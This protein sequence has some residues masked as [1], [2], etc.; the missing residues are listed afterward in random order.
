MRDVLQ[1][2]SGSNILGSKVKDFKIVLDSVKVKTPVLD[3]HP[4]RA[5]F[6]A[7]CK[8]SIK[9]MFRDHT[10]PRYLQG[11]TQNIKTVAPTYLPPIASVSTQINTTGL[12][13]WTCFGLGLIGFLTLGSL[14]LFQRVEC[15]RWQ[16]KNDEII[17][18]VTASLSD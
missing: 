3:I 16:N 15:K 10:A 6:T 14:Y 2:R 7:N 4:Y 13:G 9:N 5:Q 11:S 18:D 17:I 8:V 1:I 12:I